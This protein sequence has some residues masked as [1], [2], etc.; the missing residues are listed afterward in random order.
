MHYIYIHTYI[1][2]YLA[3]QIDLSNIDLVTFNKIMYVE[4]IQMW[5][6]IKINI[7]YI[8][9]LAALL[10]HPQCQTGILM[11]V[12]NHYFGMICGNFVASQLTGQ[13]ANVMRFTRNHYHYKIRKL[14]SLRGPL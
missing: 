14:K 3:K 1:P 8:L 11:S 12:E 5:Q 13:A 10:S 7:A 6:Q 4:S 2:L 9:L